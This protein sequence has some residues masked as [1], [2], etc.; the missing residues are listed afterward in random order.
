MHVTPLRPAAVYALP[1][2]ALI[3]GSAL[4]YAGNLQ[5]ALAPFPFDAGRELLAEET[6]GRLRRRAREGGG[7]DFAMQAPVQNLGHLK[8]NASPLNLMHPANYFHFLIEALPSFISLIERQEV[9]KD[10]VVVSGILHP[11][12]WAALRYALGQLELPVFQ[13]RPMQ[14]VTCDRVVTAQPTWHATHLLRGGISDSEFNPANLRLLR[15]RFAPLWEAT[16]KAPTQKIYVRRVSSFRSVTN[17]QEVERLAQ[18]A[19]YRIVQ[20][21]HLNFF[22]QVEL[23]SSASHIMGPTGAWAANLL[24]APE[25]AQIDVFCPETTKTDRNVWVGLGEPIGL[26]VDILYCPITRPH[27]HYPIHSDFVIPLQELAARLHA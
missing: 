7:W 16:P 24:F 2:V 15:R 14:S 20:P 26:K 17:A 5:S 18:E 13:L 12:M 1:D 8:Q 9:T 23:F 21:E 25:T 19:G 6:V 22:Q 10:S 4:V 27:K 11:N 3:G